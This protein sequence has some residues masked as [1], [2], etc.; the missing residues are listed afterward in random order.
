MTGKRRQWVTIKVAWYE[1]IENTAMAISAIGSVVLIRPA[2][3][4]NA[5][6]A[7]AR[8]AERGLKAPQAGI[9]PE[10][11]S[12]LPIDDQRRTDDFPQGRDRPQDEPSLAWPAMRPH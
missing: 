11:T 4:R 3:V 7:P 2:L 8:M 9:E 5:F 1:K 6:P 12:N 10:K